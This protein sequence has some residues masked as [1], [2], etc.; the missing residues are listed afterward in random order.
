MNIR[1]A[2][3]AIG[4]MLLSFGFFG[5]S[6]ALAYTPKSP[7]VA[8]HGFTGAWPTINNFFVCDG[9]G[10][11]GVTISA[12]ALAAATQ[13]NATRQTLNGKLA[14]GLYDLF[15]FDNPEDASNTSY[16]DFATSVP[17]IGNGVR[18]FTISTQGAKHLPPVV[19]IFGRGC[20]S[21]NCP[22]YAS[23]D[24]KRATNHE[25]GHAL[26]ILKGI[27]SAQTTWRTKF[28]ADSATY[29]TRTFTWT[30]LPTGCTSQP[31]NTFKLACW[32]GMDK[33]KFSNQAYLS[34]EFFAEEYA[35]KAAGG[36]L[37]PQAGIAL[38]TYFRTSTDY[39]FT[40]V[41]QP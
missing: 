6:P 12:P 39:V 27:P 9:T 15:Y 31:T 36:T 11:F 20:R 35:C 40:L 16:P 38:C 19:M 3:I 24:I 8:W 10:A 26:D 21:V 14:T 30:G 37:P 29:D 7:C 33:T 18:G 13:A 1:K 25:V 41:T 28:N 23:D 17:E 32:F 2:V 5:A 22:Y 4:A 34:K